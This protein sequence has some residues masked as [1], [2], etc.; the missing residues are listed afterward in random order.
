MNKKLEIGLLVDSHLIPF[1]EYAA[2]EELSNSEYS[3]ITLVIKSETT[4]FKRQK[5]VKVSFLFRLHM[6][7]DRLIFLRGKNYMLQKDLF[8]LLNN[9]PS[10]KVHTI[11]KAGHEYFD[12]NDISKIRRYNPDIIIKL[13]YGLPEGD[14]LKVPVYG[15]WSF[16][17][18]NCKSEEEDTAGYYEVVRRIPVTSS[19]L[20]ILKGKGDK[21]TVL[22]RVFE[23][24]CSY[25]VHLNRD[26][27][28]RRASYAIPRVVKG[29]KLYGSDYLM[30]LVEKCDQEDAVLAEQA[31]PPSSHLSLV[32]LMIFKKIFL[33]KILKK[34]IFDDP[35]LW[36]LLFRISPEKDFTNFSY[37]DF[38]QLKPSKDKFWADPFVVSKDGNYFVFVEEFIYRRN[39]GHISVLKLNNSGQLLKFNKIIEKPYHMSYPFIFNMDNEFYMIPETGENRTIDLYKCIE[40]PDKW[41]FVQNLMNNVNAV[42]TTLFQYADKWWLFTLIDT[43]DHH[44]GGSPELYLFYADDLFSGNWIS[45]PLNPVISDVRNARPAGKIFV[46]EDKI[47]RPSQDCSVR[48]G[49]SFSINQIISLSE[50]EYKEKPL[51]KVSPDWNDILKGAHTFNFD[52]DFTIID[53]YTFRNRFLNL[54]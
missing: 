31:P 22:T 6:K 49:Q 25:S 45:H 42:D 13:C 15:V 26:K 50:I 18:L 5:S 51:L 36:T 38:R 23:S 9:V 10:I 47:F 8:V 11:K 17:M 1:W 46:R 32:N 34:V 4:T 28:F 27:I 21:N 3:L 40:F 33:S 44:L 48:Y 16:S 37:K 20:V 35:F 24:T 14:I 39:K 53:T 43:M 12:A 7:I 54:V 29:M 41:T 30:K 2:I 19:E 52:D